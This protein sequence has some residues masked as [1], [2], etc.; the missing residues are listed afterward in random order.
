MAAALREAGGAPDTI[1]FEGRDH[2]GASLAGGE[3]DGPWVSR[4]LDW[5]TDN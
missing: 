1:V 3:T 2:F 4:A 5:M